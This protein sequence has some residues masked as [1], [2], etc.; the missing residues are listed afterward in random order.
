[1]EAARNT[2]VEKRE[3]ATTEAPEVSFTFIS[4]ARYWSRYQSFLFYFE[5]FWT[6]DTVLRSSATLF[7]L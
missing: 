1:M 6:A 3:S 4:G 5:H 2:Q 7:I